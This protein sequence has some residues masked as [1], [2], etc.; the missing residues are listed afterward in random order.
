[1]GIWLRKLDSEGSDCVVRCGSDFLRKLS[2]S[3]S[4]LRF[5]AVLSGKSCDLELVSKHLADVG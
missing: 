3:W 2:G 4:L 5:Y 1:M